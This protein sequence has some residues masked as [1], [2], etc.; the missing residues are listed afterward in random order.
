MDLVLYKAYVEKYGKPPEP[1]AGP[2]DP[3]KLDQKDQVFVSAN[4]ALLQCNVCATTS[5]LH[6]CG[7]CVDSVYCGKDCQAIDWETHRKNC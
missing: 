1:Y 7:K 3:E 5:N 6:W 2:T 4:N